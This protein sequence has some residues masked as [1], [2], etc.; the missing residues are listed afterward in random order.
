M[1]VEFWL[2]WLEAKETG[3]WKGS[4]GGSAVM[5]SP[6]ISLGFKDLEGKGYD[7]M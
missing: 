5:G 3:S 2:C 1:E 7:R 6:A 4:V